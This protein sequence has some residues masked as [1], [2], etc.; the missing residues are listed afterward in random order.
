[1]SAATGL[2]QISKFSMFY[3][4]LIIPALAI[5]MYFYKNKPGQIKKISL[6]N[7]I[8]FAGLFI[9]INWLIIS[10]AHLFYQPFLPLKDY[11]F[12]SN[13]FKGLQHFFSGF[14]SWL[15]VPFPS[16]YVSSMDAVM[17]FDQL[18]GG[19]TGSLNGKPYLLGHSSAKGFWDYYFVVMFFKLPVTV[20]LLWIGTA[21]LSIRKFNKSA[22][23]NNELFLVLPAIFY[24]IYMNFFYSTQ[25]G[26]RHIMIIFPLL[27]I[28]SG[29]LITIL[30][31]SDKKYILYG[32][33]VYQAISVG[34]Y[35]PH[36]LP[37]TNEFIWNKK[38]AFKKIADSNICYGE[39]YRFLT[40]YLSKNK[41]AIFRPEQPIAGKVVMEIND[42][43]NLD[44]KTMGKYD[45][46][47]NLSPASHIHSQYMIYQ[48][49]QS[50]V[51]SVNYSRR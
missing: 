2:A 39:G 26:I 30:L 14:A 13:S 16:S 31:S 6:R 46:V 27:Y 37:Y 24:L 50:Y 43:V 17:Y 15:P 34:C 22:F 38:S 47:K 42:I 8:G 4:F 9:L 20:L 41:E 19:A 33:M 11:T 29:K 49:P 28:F 35:F 7:M 51:D 10:A 44:I 36:F 1:M 5:I 21:L 48:V 32:L 25:L 23:L 18:G 12:I 40:D 3:L 45:W